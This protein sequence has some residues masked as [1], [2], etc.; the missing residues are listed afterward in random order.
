[1]VWRKDHRPLITQFVQRRDI[2]TARTQQGQDAQI[3]AEHGCDGLPPQ[4]APGHFRHERMQHRRHQRPTQAKHT[5][6]TEADVQAEDLVQRGE[7]TWRSL[8]HGVTQSSTWTFCDDSPSTQAI[9]T[10]AA[11]ARSRST[12]GLSAKAA[13]RRVS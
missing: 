7:T 9:A 5:K 6:G 12:S 8:S 10:P 4:P 2:E 1:M 13:P 3:D 11:Q